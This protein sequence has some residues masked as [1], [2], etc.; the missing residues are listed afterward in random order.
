M[1]AFAAYTSADT[2][3]V[4]QWAGQPPSQKNA[5]DRSKS[6]KTFAVTFRHFDRADEC[7]RRMELREHIANCACI[8]NVAVKY[9]ASSWV[10]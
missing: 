2:P 4:F 5:A 6:R 8:Q 9:T 10:D 3:D 1:I 7:S